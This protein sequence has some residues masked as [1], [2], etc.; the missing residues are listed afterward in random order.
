MQYKVQACYATPM[1]E[2]MLHCIKHMV[3]IFGSHPCYRVL[4]VW[5]SEIISTKFTYKEP[6]LK[7]FVLHKNKINQQ[8]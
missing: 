4:K 2:I 6:V 1:Q 8:Q 3:F 5:N 7:E